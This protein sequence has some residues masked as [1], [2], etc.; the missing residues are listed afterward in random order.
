M[1][2]IAHS[3]L[4]LRN[5]YDRVLASDLLRAAKVD[6]VPYSLVKFHGKLACKCP[7]FT[8]EEIGFVSAHRFFNRNFDIDDMLAFSAEH[9]AEEAFR[10]M[11]VMDAVMQ[12]STATPAIRAKLVAL[13]DFEYKDPGFGY[14]RWKLDAV[15]RLKDRQVAKI[16]E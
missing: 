9:G 4:A 5:A 1:G 8:S 10:E 13:S 3:E 11:I 6:H 15:N 7:I 14:P 16:L 2:D 12:T